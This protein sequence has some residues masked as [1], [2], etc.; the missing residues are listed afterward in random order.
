MWVGLGQY[1]HARWLKCPSC[2]VSF[3]ETTRSSDGSTIVVFMCVICVGVAAAATGLGGLVAPPVA[4]NLAEPVSTQSVVRY[5]QQ[6]SA[7]PEMPISRSLAGKKCAKRGAERVSQGVTLVCRKQGKK[8]IWV[9]K[10]TRVVPPTAPSEPIYEPPTTGS[11][12]V[13]SCQ[14]I[15]VSQ[16]RRRFNDQ[17]SGFPTLERYVAHQGTVRMALIP[18][19]WADLP[20][21]AAFIQSATTQT[22]K[23]TEWYENV[24]DGR[25][26]VEW[27]I[28][29]E[30]IRLP[31][32]AN[33]Y[34][35]PFSGDRTATANFFGRVI[36]SVDPS[37]DFSG[38]QV[39]NFLLP[40]GQS[41]VRESVQDW[42]WEEFTARF[43]N[44][45][46]LISAAAAGAYFDQR[47]REYWSYWAHEFG[48]VLQLAHVGSSRRWS[49]MHG[50]DIMGS[51]DGPTRE[52]SGWMRFLA[53]W[54]SDDQ[55]FCQ[56]KSAL[57]PTTL[58]LNPVNERKPGVKAAIIRVSPTEAIIIE[59]RRP[60]EWRCSTVNN[61]AYR[62][63][64]V[65]VYTYDATKGGQEEFL[66]A[67]RPDGRPSVG[68]GCWTEPEPN[69]LLQFGESVTVKGVTVSVARGGPGNQ[70]DTV[71][72]APS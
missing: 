31:G 66:E 50:Y 40:Q 12:P 19:D 16:E 8:L 39:A 38:V 37:F 32:S 23:L 6:T 28:H 49:S 27:V 2:E 22:R 41:I 33:A 11:A 29:P 3:C 56:E 13:S 1:P 63:S 20:G 21:D 5:Q 26:R 30:W 52:L 18:I 65:L 4:E 62:T 14:V 70:Y 72:I 17:A 68:S 24:S 35:V 43:T 67:V 7:L 55:I 59:S 57:Q 9:R 10:P 51:Q 64:G 42:P 25:L 36:P 60:T 61:P 53:G 54:L 58:M 47:P 71:T 15:E 69:P 46:Q 44:E 45:G 48:H 34:S